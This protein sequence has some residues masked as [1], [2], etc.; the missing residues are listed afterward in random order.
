[1]Y[2]VYLDSIF[3]YGVTAFNSPKSRKLTTYNGIGTGYFPKADDPDLKEWSWECQLQ[4]YPEHYHGPG[5]A[6]AKTIMAGLEEMLESKEPVR[7]VVKSKYSSIS[8]QVLV[9]S[10]QCKEV[11]AG[12]YNVSVNVTQYKEAAVR[13]AEIPEIPRPGKIP[14]A[15]PHP[16]PVNQTAYDQSDEPFRSWHKGYGTP[17]APVNPV[18]TDAATGRVEALPVDPDPKK[19]YGFGGPNYDPRRPWAEDNKYISERIKEVI[20]NIQHNSPYYEEN[21]KTLEAIKD[22]YNRF[23]DS[24]R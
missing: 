15:P 1:M 4:E 2:E 6:P 12:V 24:F 22:A 11:Y 21:Q 8:E 10:C 9:K 17:L 18:V 13:E 16:V 14:Q 19:F 3:F 20:S 23:K 5:F 7:L